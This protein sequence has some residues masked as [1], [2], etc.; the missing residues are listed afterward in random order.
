MNMIDNLKNRLIEAIVKEARKENLTQKQ[1]AVV[2]DTT[3]PRISNMFQ[4]EIAKFSL[5]TLFKYVYALNIQ[6]QVTIF[7][8]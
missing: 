3:Q 4:Y 5:D 2:L 7:G 8:E 1:L 6:T